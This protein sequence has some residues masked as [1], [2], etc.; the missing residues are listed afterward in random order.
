A[1]FMHNAAT[2]LRLLLWMG[3]R[4]QEACPQT[5]LNPRT[6]A[7]S[8]AAGEGMPTPLLSVRGLPRADVEK[9]VQ[10]SNAHLL[11]DRHLSIAL[12]NGPRF[13]VVAGH[14][15]SLYGLNVRLRS[16]KAEPGVSQARVP[17]S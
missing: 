16:L 2:A 11:E 13:V 17:F 5:T 12:T 6:Q 15:E 1:S 3:A 10:A 7:D 9:H 8:L 14:P 4:L